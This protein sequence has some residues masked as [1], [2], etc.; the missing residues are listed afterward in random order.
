[1][2]KRFEERISGTVQLE[3]AAADGRRYLSAV[4]VTADI[5]NANGRRYPAAVLREAVQRV[6][7]HLHESAGQGRLGVVTGEAEHPNDKGQRPRY[8][9]T[10]VNWNAGHVRYNEGTGQV[11]LR[12]LVLETSAG[13]DALAIMAGGVLPSISLRAYGDSVFVTEGNRQVEEVT[14]LTFTGFDLLAPNE[15]SDPNARAYL[16]ENKNTMTK[17]ELLKLIQENM[18]LFNESIAQQVKDANAAQLK[19][20]EEMI[21]TTLGV[22]AADDLGRALQ[23]A[24]E[25]KKLLAEQKRAAAVEGAIATHTKE[26]PYGKLNEAFVAE[27]RGLGIQEANAVP[28]V[29]KS[30]RSR[31]DAM[32]AQAK[33][34]GMGMVEML[35]PVFETET[36]Q[37]EFT[38]AAFAFTE[39]MV[40]R[41]LASP[42]DLRKGTSRAE[43]YARRY[44]EAFD[45][46]YKPHLLRESRQ[47]EEAMAVSDLNLPYS[48]MR[49]IVLEAVPELVAANVFDFGMVEVSPGRLY[50]EAY[51]AESGA[52]PAITDES[53]TS[54]ESA[55]IDLAQNRLQPGTVVV[56]S[57]PA[58]TTYAEFTDYLIDYGEGRMYTLA[59]GSIGDATALLVD[60]TYD[61]V[62]TGEGGAIQR[63]KGTLSYQTIETAADRLAQ[64]IYDEAVVFAQTQ[65]GWDATTRTMSMIVREIREM[66]DKH[67]FYLAIASAHI[68][69]N[70]GGTWASS[71]D[72]V[73]ELVEKLGVAKV[74]VQNDHYTPTAFT[75]SL[76][77]ADRLD[78]WDGFTAAGTRANISA[79]RGALGAGDTGLRIKGLPV[80]AS[81]QMPDTKA[82]VTH[83]EAVQHRVLS[84]RPM[85]MKGPY[86]SYSSTNLVAADQYYVEEYNATVSLITAKA[87]Y[88]T[89][90]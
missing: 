60:Y 57:D 56:T 18:G 81:K 5:V 38:K 74:A 37:P 53:V 71:T 19:G 88:L 26:L 87:G 52:Q 24:V 86:P 75:M 2:E 77:N 90:S 49:A 69:A 85:S 83:P 22:G 28:E 54:D 73:S 66:I 12:G 39:R 62:R 15:Q 6:N 59:S 23:E 44:L 51:S 21:R 68:A 8:L 29:V 11:E 89:I 17:E 33:A 63:G 36:G 14:D 1:M 45:A 80:F 84:S 43:L 42:R 46:A 55:W 41:G 16:L 34:A 79:G 30:L 40:E 32:L 20:L 64:Q 72:P 25:A 9:E 47:M 10:I 27:L 4:G 61:K 35:G 70:T 13:R 65:L 58:G 48:V 76:T 3:E 67:A 31:Y 50:F 78:N 82:L 7:A